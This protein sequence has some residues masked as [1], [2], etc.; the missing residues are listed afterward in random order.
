MDTKEKLD[1][2]EFYCKD[3]DETILK[4]KHKIEDMAN[5]LSKRSAQIGDLKNKLIKAQQE[6]IELKRENKTPR[7]LVEKALQNLISANYIWENSKIFVPYIK[8]A[9]E[10]I[11]GILRSL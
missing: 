3:K 11:Q 6:I 9:I 5:T 1:V 7:A 2:K 10:D 4:L 8:P